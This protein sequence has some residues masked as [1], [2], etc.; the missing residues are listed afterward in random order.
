MFEQIIEPERTIEINL[1]SS[2]KYHQPKKYQK[3]FV[4]L[5]GTGGTGSYVARDLLRCISNLKTDLGIV[6]SV[7][8]IDPDKVEPKNLVRQNFIPSDVGK[9]KAD[10]LASRYSSAFGVKTYAIN[11]K[12]DFTTFIAL[13]EELTKDERFVAY[14]KDLTNLFISCTDNNQSRRD[15]YDALLNKNNQYSITQYPTYWIDSGNEKKSGQ[16]IAGFLPPL[17]WDGVPISLL[18]KV[19][20]EMNMLNCFMPLSPIAYPDILNKEKDSKEEVSCAE[21]AIEQPQNMFI[22]IT[23]ATHILNFVRQI[24][25]GQKMFSYGIEFNLNGRTD[26]LRNTQETAK[27]IRTFSD[28]WEK[29]KCHLPLTTT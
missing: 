1:L 24:V 11:K 20:P 10:V 2:L 12:F 8:F 4:T 22:N 18:T 27:Q 16:V 3:L 7:V 14:S 23:A 17:S 9:Y 15:I 21:A 13:R 19:Y 29:R 28:H 5:I 26:L 25:Y 6:P